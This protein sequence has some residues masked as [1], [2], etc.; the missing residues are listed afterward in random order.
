MVFLS[1]CWSAS[2]LGE[3]SRC[4]ASVMEF[5]IW[6]IVHSLDSCMPV[7]L[8]LAARQSSY[9]ESKICYRFLPTFSFVFCPDFVDICPFLC[10]GQLFGLLF[11]I[12]LLYFLK[13]VPIWLSV[14]G[15]AWILPK[16]KNNTLVSVFSCKC[17][18]WLPTH[19]QSHVMLFICYFIF[20]SGVFTNKA[21]A[22][23]KTTWMNNCGRVGIVWLERDTARL[24]T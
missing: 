1:T 11:V 15:D 17:G 7:F 10:C 22:K 12:R 21:V 3:I 18:V 6:H 19:I 9:L 5:G 14:K 2:S 4:S 13:C 20:H 24:V 8:K 23:L 16:F